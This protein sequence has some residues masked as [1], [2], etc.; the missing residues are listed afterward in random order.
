MPKEEHTQGWFCVHTRVYMC[1]LGSVCV[2]M[3]MLA[4]TY[5]WIYG[6]CS[7]NHRHFFFTAVL[8]CDYYIDRR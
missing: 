2:A 1:Y 8:L 7:E 6:E 3:P 5:I 4:W